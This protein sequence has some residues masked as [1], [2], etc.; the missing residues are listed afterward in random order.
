MI[1]NPS[2]CH[3][4]FEFVCIGILEVLHYIKNLGTMNTLE[5]H[6]MIHNE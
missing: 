2:T 4:Y 3:L 6:L 5:Y 1:S